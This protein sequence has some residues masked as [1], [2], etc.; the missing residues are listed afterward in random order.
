MLISDAVRTFC[1]VKKFSPLEICTIRYSGNSHSLRNSVR[2]MRSFH[3]ANVCCGSRKPPSCQQRC[4]YAVYSTKLQ[5]NL[6]MPR[7]FGKYYA[8]KREISLIQLS[9]SLFVVPLLPCLQYSASYFCI[10]VLE[11]FVEDRADYP[12][13]TP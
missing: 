13:K 6:D 2:G 12:L 10:Q 4:F 11:S 1:V 7:L 8:A 9:N 5:H 3:L